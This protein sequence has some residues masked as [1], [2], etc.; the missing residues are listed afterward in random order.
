MQTRNLA[1]T[2]LSN[3]QIVTDLD[4][5]EDNAALTAQGHS[6]RHVETWHDHDTT[7]I[8]WDA[9]QITEADCPF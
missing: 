9:P 6:I 1:M 8:T 5:D 2:Q 7:C 3:G 4:A